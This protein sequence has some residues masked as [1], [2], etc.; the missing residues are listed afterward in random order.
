MAKVKAPLLS[1]KAKGTL[2]DTITFAR[3][4]GQNIAETKPRPKDTYTLRQ[5]YHRWLYTDYLAEWNILTDAEKLVWY[6]AGAKV[7]NTPVG[8]WLKDKLANLA[9]IQG[10]WHLDTI[11]GG[12][13]PDFSKNLNHGTIEGPTLAAG[14]IDKCLYFN[15]VDD[16]VNC[17]TDLSLNLTG[18]FTFIGHF[19]PERVASCF[20]IE[21]MKSDWSDGYYINFIN[22]GAL[23]MRVYTPA[24]KYFATDPDA[25]IINEW[26]TYAFIR[27]GDA[28]F[29]YK[30][31]VDITEDT[32]VLADPVATDAQFTIGLRF[33]ALN[34]QYKGWIDELR[35]YNRALTSAERQSFQDKRYP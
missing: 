10:G 6:N 21:R 26:H 14:V 1:F 27:S 33:P 7:N 15:G 22:N 13:T 2:A 4:Q 11:G 9:D 16:Y 12:V 31:N 23:L 25:Y 3:R 24:P 30:D 8:E 19:K 28:G 5:F 32:D 17:G 35:L 34:M 18:D 20:A 29:I